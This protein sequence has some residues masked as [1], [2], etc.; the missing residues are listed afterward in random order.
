MSIISYSTWYCTSSFNGMFMRCS[1]KWAWYSNSGFTISG[2]TA[3]SWKWACVSMS[4]CRITAK[5][6]ILFSCCYITICVLRYSVNK[7]SSATW[8]W[9]TWNRCLNN[10][11]ISFVTKFFPFRTIP[12]ILFITIKNNTTIFLFMIFTINNNWFC[13]CIVNNI[14]CGCTMIF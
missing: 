1:T 9:W 12:N 3:W 11:I 2:C 7:S 8:C 14:C 13:C 5:I 4:C 6:N 10:F